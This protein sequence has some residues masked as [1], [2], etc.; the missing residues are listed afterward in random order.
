MKRKARMKPVGRRSSRSSARAKAGLALMRT[1]QRW[2]W[3]RRPTAN[4]IWSTTNEPIAAQMHAGTSGT[5]P[6][7]AS[8]PPVTT[9]ASPSTPAPSRIAS[10]PYFAT[11]VSIVIYAGCPLV[12]D[13][14]S[15][16]AQAL[17]YDGAGIARRGGD[18]MPR[19][20]EHAIVV[21][22]VELPDMGEGGRLHR[23]G[24]RLAVRDIAKP[25]TLPARR[26]GRGSTGARAARQ[27]EVALMEL[28]GGHAVEHNKIAA[29]EIDRGVAAIL[30]QRVLHVLPGVADRGEIDL[31]HAGLEVADH[32]AAGAMLEHEG[33]GTGLA[34]Q[35]VIAALAVE[36]VVAGAAEQVI[37]AGDAGEVVV[38]SV[39]D[40]E[41]RVAEQD[42]VFDIVV[43]IITGA[44]DPGIDRVVPLVGLYENEVVRRVDIEGVV[45]G[46]AVHPVIIAEM[47]VAMDDVDAIATP[48]DLGGEVVAADQRI[49]ASLAVDR[50]G[51][52]M[53]VQ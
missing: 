39:A 37:A 29:T 23:L 15:A 4:Q 17:G 45:A 43:E 1:I 44:T 42:Q 49:V 5:S 26:R 48:K 12:R 9:T 16:N 38:E 2:F 33:V 31:V 34:E 51:L 14:A 52:K 18:V 28:G 35:H 22:N 6:R 21:G 50:I 11:R 7:C 24:Y 46:I 10:R 40:D 36:H 32:V 47:A 8:T 53:A 19:H 25:R 3:K 27:D 13:D 30:V 20:G 41:R